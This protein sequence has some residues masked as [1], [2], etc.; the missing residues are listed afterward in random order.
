MTK[1]SLGRKGFILSYTP[2]EQSLTKGNQSRNSRQE[3][4]AGSGEE[5]AREECCLQCCSSRFSEA[6]SSLHLGSQP[7]GD[8]THSEQGP[9]TSISH[10]K[11]APELDHR[12]IW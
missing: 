8:N 9:P 7:R 1:S 11:N 12:P 3:P 5:E 6:A 10:Q 4:E 2:R